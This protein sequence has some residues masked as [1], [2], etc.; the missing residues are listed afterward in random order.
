M[1]IGA[2]F[3]TSSIVT[4]RQSQ[5][6]HEKDAQCAPGASLVPL[7]GR[8]DID[9]S[10]EVEG[11]SNFGSVSAV[12]VSLT[13]GVW[14]YEIQLITSGLIQIGWIDGHFQA[15]SDQGEGVGDH[16]HSWSYDGN[17]Q[18]RWNSGSSTYGE[19][20]QSDDIIGCLLDLEGGKMHFYRK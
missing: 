12:N 6:S 18:R 19:R 4:E 3:Y 9:D 11:L 2:G 1:H 14:Y 10:G 5:N 8:V 7:C 16:V 17:R 13:S 20:W 15:S